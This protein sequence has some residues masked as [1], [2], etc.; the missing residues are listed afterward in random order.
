MLLA[1]PRP[2]RDDDPDAALVNNFL[3]PVFRLAVNEPTPK[4]RLAATVKACD[5]LKS[6]SYVSGIWC[7]TKLVSNVMPVGAMKKIVSEA[8]SKLTCNITSVP[9]PDEEMEFEGK[10]VKEVQ[11]MFV[12]NV[13][14][15]SLLSYNGNLHW[16][17]VSDPE[18]IAEPEFFGKYF[19]EELEAMAKA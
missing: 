16:N 17:M 3:T 6:K 4:G 7:L 8:I 14:Q 1:L 19:M 13:P 9:L 12:N 18:L 10:P 11:V 2:V 5:E 15:I